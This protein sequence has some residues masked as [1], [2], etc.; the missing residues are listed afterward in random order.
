MNS[1]Q[2]SIIQKSGYDNGWEHGVASDAETVRM[3]SALHPVAV[4]ISMDETGIWELSFDSDRLV[5]ELARS[6]PDSGG[7]EGSFLASTEAGLGRLLRRAA[8]LAQALPDQAAQTFA[9][10][11]EDEI[12]EIDDF[13]TEVERLVRQRVGQDVFRKALMDYW[14][15]ACAVSGISLPQILRA[16]HAKPWKDCASDAERLNVYNGL[17][18]TAN[19]DAL[20]DRGLVTFVDDGT[21]RISSTVSHKLRNQLSPEI[22]NAR[23]RWVAAEHQ[24]FLQWHR[25]RV[26]IAG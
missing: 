3:A 19:L 11:V 25:D 14:G 2:Q 23:L 1:L 16:S 4:S 26:F 21:I 17:L 10:A 13:S 9:K 18:L 6:F 12:E 22:G 24:P 7:V 5:R 8:R 20:F 15:S